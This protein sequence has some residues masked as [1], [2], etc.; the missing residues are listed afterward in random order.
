MV[1]FEEGTITKEELVEMTKGLLGIRY[2]TNKDSSFE[3]YANVWTIGVDIFRNIR[4]KMKN[5]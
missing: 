5:N 1:T 3:A 4:R 2:R